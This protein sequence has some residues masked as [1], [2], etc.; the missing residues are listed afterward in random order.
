MCLLCRKRKSKKRQLFPL[1][2]DVEERQV[3]QQES[4]DFKVV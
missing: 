2:E 3:L 4:I 1:D